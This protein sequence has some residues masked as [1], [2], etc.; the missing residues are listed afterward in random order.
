MLCVCVCVFALRRHAKTAQRRKERRLQED[1]KRQRQISGKSVF[2][3]FV[4]YISNINIIVNN[5]VSRFNRIQNY[6]KIMCK[7]FGGSLVL[8]V[9]C[10]LSQYICCTLGPVSTG[11]GGSAG[12]S[13]SSQPSRSTQPG[14]PF[15]VGKMSTSENYKVNRHST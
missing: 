9:R 12:I 1:L 4:E 3:L 2:K 13:V 8:L 10:C 6:F 15:G 14:H 5:R 7:I 11:T